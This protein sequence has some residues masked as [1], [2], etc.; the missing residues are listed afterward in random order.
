MKQ[1]SWSVL[2]GCHS[3]FHCILVLIAWVRYYRKLPTWREI[4]CIFIHDIGHWGK[5]YL[6]DP[7]LKHQHWELGALL[8]ERLFGDKGFKLVAGHDHY[9]GYPESKLL[10]PD[11]ISFAIAPKWWLYSNLLVEPKIR[12]NGMGRWEHVS[13]FKRTVRANVIAGNYMS[14]HDV[15]LEQ[16]ERLKGD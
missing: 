6:D 1:G 2:F 4:I 15:F 10:K 7:E 8:A 11:K 5:D 3:W 9:S 12:S 14:N 13:A 16:K